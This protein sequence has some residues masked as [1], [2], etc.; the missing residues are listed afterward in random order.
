VTSFNSTLAL[1]F[2]EFLEEVG[3]DLGT[4]L[5]DECILIFATIVVFLRN[6]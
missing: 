2:G 3:L 6:D 1:D 5:R 4:S